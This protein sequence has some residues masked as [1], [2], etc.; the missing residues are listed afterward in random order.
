MSL[1]D[2]ARALGI[3]K[4]SASVGTRQLL[5]WSAIRQVWVKGTRRDHFEAV[6]E[7]RE[8]LR[9]VYHDFFRPTIDISQARY[10]RL[11]TLLAEDAQ[12][13]TLTPQEQEFCRERIRRIG[14]LQERLKAV[15]P[16]VEQFL[17]G[18]REIDTKT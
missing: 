18:G 17:N 10:E 11:N 15:L 3:S 14:R 16:L 8:V 4:A 12:A 7:L 6:P 13:G 1:E 2:I 9:R 5:A